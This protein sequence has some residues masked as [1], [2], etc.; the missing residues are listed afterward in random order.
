MIN[1]FLEALEQYFAPIMLGWL[2]VAIYF[3]TSC[4]TLNPIIDSLEEQE[5]ECKARGGAFILDQDSMTVRCVMPEPEPGP[6]EAPQPE[7]PPDPV[8][9]TD[10][11]PD[12]EPPVE[13]PVQGEWRMFNVGEYITIPY[14]GHLV[15]EVKG[16]DTRKPKEW[17]LFDFANGRGR[18]VEVANAHMMLFD[19]RTLY[20]IQ[21]VYSPAPLR[22][23]RH[24]DYWPFRPDQTYKWIVDSTLH[25]IRIQI[26]Q[27]GALVVDMPRAQMGP[28]PVVPFARITDIRLGCGVFGSHPCPNP[29]Q[30]KVE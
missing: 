9:I 29:I 17:H 21:Q 4:A 23:N 18:G 28:W 19:D 8:I 15:F 1:R 7:P 2:I 25:G 26:F 10:P 22:E 13:P 5:A 6:G 12:P 11:V 14:R 20:L 27:D 16:L 30:I 24:E 3:L